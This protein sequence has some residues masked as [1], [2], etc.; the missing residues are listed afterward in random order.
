MPFGW[1]S[2]KTGTLFRTLA[3]QLEKLARFWHFKSVLD[4]IY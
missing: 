4:N 3:H 2:W 1:R